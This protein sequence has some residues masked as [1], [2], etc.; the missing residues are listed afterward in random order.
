MFMIV[1]YSLNSWSRSRCT[2]LAM[3]P[4]DGKSQN[5]QISPT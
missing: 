2:I 1:I 4:F 3:T 5:L